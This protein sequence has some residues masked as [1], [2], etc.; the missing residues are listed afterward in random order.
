MISNYL[1]IIFRLITRQKTFAF[2]NIFGLAIGMIGFILIFLFVRYELAFDKH[3]ANIDRLYQVV[4][5][6][7][8]DNNVYNFTPVPYPFKEAV[9]TEFPEIEKATRLDGWNK[10]IFRY[11]EKVFDEPVVMA[12]PEIFDMFTFNILE[13]NRPDFL[14]NNQSVVISRRIAEKYFAGESSAL[15]KVFQVNGKYDLVVS[16]IFENLPPTSTLR[17]DI[18]MPVDFFKELGRDLT[19]WQSN[20]INLYILLHGGTD[21]ATFENKLKPRLGKAQPADKPDVLFLHPFKDLHLHSYHYKDGPIKYVFIFSLI[22]IVILGLAAINYV[23]LVTARSVRR[24]KE[25]GIRKTVGAL[26]SQV[27][28]QF[29]SESILFALIAL[30]FA[31]IAVELL[32]PWFNVLLGIEL[33]I[34]YTNPALMLSLLGIA[35]GAGL[36]AGLYPAFYLANFSPSSVLKSSGKLTG[37]SFKSALVVVQFSV[38]IALIITSIVWYKQF[39]YMSSMDVGL[40]KENIFY[41]RLEDEVQKHFETVQ[42]DFSQIPAVSSVSSAGH[43]PTE[44]FSNGGGYAWEGKDPNQDVLISSTRVDD[45]Y[46]K[47]FGIKLKEGRFFQPGENPLDTANKIVKMVANER[48]TEIA[49]FKD[50]IGKSISR[51]SWRFEI[52]GVVENFNF[53][54]MRSE[55]GPLMMFYSPNGLQY[56]FVKVNGNPADVK[57]ELEARYSK[58]FPQ[59]PPNFQ[60]VDDRFQMYFGRESRMAGIFGYFTLLAILISCLGLYGLASFIAEQRRKE[61]GIRKALGANTSGLSFLMLKDFAV[62]IVISNVIAIPLAWYYANDM[63]SKYVFRTEI[64]AWIFIIAA[65]LSVVI[66]CFTVIF[67]VTK[68]AKQNPAMVLKYE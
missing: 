66:A 54:Q 31:V 67:Q 61:M 39:Q 48:L 7:H 13:G 11:E 43:L 51:D 17:A 59:Y 63:L 26:K 25:I 19:N 29:L 1:K 3:H 16:G 9:A 44:I 21:V 22:G 42:K 15:G 50:P 10:F 41:F 23:N 60:L 36:L 2:I 20:S 12:D 49:N 32:L 28:F 64:S 58:M 52:I 47:T 62:W 57:K 8:L 24:A 4:R 68:T 40:S 5:D 46:L 30:N 33:N 45:G 55:E 14:A 35:V 56:G 53:L 38:S 6:V 34:E 18:F 37:G 65:M 27:I